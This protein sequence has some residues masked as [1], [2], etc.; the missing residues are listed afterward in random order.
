MVL[1]LRGESVKFALGWEKREEVQDALCECER[2]TT[3]ASSSQLFCLKTINK[4]RL[5]L[6][7][8]STAVAR[9]AQATL[10]LAWKRGIA[11]PYLA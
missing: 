2:Q 4:E 6:A 1:K 10:S 5:V 3:S 11:E 8:P 7:Q 9:T